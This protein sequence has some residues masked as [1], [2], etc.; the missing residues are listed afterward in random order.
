MKRDEL[1]PSRRCDGVAVRRARAATGK[2][3]IVGF[4]G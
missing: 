4:L 2:V 3:P 1:A